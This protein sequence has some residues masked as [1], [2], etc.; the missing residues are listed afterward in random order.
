M[1]RDRPW[2]KMWVEWLGDAKMDRLSLAEQGAWWRLVSLSHECEHTDAQTVDAT[3]PHGKPDGALVVAGSPLS[4]AEIMKSLKIADEADK[5]VFNQ[6]L[7]KMKHGGS[8]HWNSNTLFVTH[9]EERQRATTDTKEARRQRQRDLRESKKRE[10]EKN[11]SPPIEEEEEV[12][13]ERR[14]THA[15]T[16]N[17]KAV[18][19][20]AE[21]SRCYERYIGLLNPLDADRIREF[22][23][24][25]EKHAGKID[26]VEEGF[27]TAPTN[28]RRWPYVQAILERYVEEGGPDDKSRQP[29]GRGGEKPGDGAYR[30]DTAPGDE[31]PWTVVRG[32]ES[33]EE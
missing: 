9:Y 8:L 5:A 26:W 2:L 19:L 13:G 12:R 4:L 20:I 30:G 7:E 1:S 22:S 15:Q 17:E 23:E 6:M 18:T 31:Y 28:K 25:Y 27:K 29:G 21:F 24:Y 33:D 3:H 32:E 14:E 10:A 11:P 16:S